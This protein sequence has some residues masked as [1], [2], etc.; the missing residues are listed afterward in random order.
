MM[1]NFVEVSS[2]R[3]MGPAGVQ[4]LGGDA[5]LRAQAEFAAVGEARGGV[6]IDRRRIHPL[7]KRAAA[8]SHSRS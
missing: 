1:M 5:D 2:R 8:V 4:L 7:R 3:P 6:D